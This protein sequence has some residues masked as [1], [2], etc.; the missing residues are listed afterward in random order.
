MSQPEVYAPRI[1]ELVRDRR[2]NP[3]GPGCPNSAVRTH[4]DAL[5]VAT[6]FAPHKV[7][8]ADMATACLAGLWLYH[9]F[10][11]ESHTLSQDIATPSGSYW[12]GLMHRRE[13]DFSNA[14]YWFHRVGQHP[15]FVPLQAAAAALA[16]D[17]PEKA[18]AF[19]TTQASWDPFAFIDL[20]EAAQTGRAKTEMLCRKIQQR[21]WELLFDCCYH[22][23]LGNDA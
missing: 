12:H 19:L 5:S 20:C 23:A 4:L 6:A 7:R 11:D 17:S 14:K 16:A 13:P 9:D 22:H 3:L 8:D 1:A 18:A 21:E 15:V 2:L 10:L